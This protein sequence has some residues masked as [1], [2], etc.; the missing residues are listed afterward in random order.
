MFVKQT[1]ADKPYDS[2]YHCYMVR[3]I[4]EP[5]KHWCCG[6]VRARETMDEGNTVL[7]CNVTR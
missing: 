6:L 3:M 4:V 5:H 1:E 7:G 2:L